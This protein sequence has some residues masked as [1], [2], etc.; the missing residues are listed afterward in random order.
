MFLSILMFLSLSN[1]FAQQVDVD[2]V[3]AYH[4][5]GSE[6]SKQ[7]APSFVIVEADGS[8]SILS[9]ENTTVDRLNTPFDPEAGLVRKF[10]IST[11]GV[12]RIDLPFKGKRGQATCSGLRKK[13]GSKI[14]RGTLRLD[15]TEV[16]EDVVVF[17][18]TDVG[19]NEKA[20]FVSLGDAAV[21]DSESNI[22]LANSVR[23]SFLEVET[24]R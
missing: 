11:G 3:G 2:R 5:A 6:L 8:K 24:G 14:G 10:A 23:N 21:E 15:M 13:D 19:G 7:D 12:C 20:L 18:G 22:G 17:K 9:S 1:L 16:T 4:N